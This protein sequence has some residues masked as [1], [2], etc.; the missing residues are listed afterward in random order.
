LKLLGIYRHPIFSNNAIDADRQILEDSIARLQ[1]LSPLPFQVE[2]AEEGEVKNLA[3]SYSLVLT[4]A[5]SEE[6]LAAL[7]KALPGAPIW[8]STAAIRNCYRKAMSEMLIAL[9]VGYVPYELLPTDGSRKPTLAENETYWLKRSDFHAIADEDVTLAESPEEVE[10]KLKR[11]QSRGVLEVILQRHIH[12]DIYKFYGVKGGFFRPIQVRKFLSS[13]AT[14]DLSGLERK[15]SLAAEALGLL[16]YGGDAV[17][18]QNGDFHL[19]DVNDWPSF[20]LCR[21][22]AAQ[23]IAELSLSHLLARES[24]KSASLSAPGI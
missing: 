16:I 10:A 22:E 20:R 4:M 13:P 7:D 2:M 12:G 19:I 3:G 8:N 1:R 23:A 9:P 14:P 15:A 24:R 21:D 6:S 11:F 5:Q 18:D 17:L